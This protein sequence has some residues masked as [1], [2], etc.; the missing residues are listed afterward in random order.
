MKAD[1]KEVVTIRIGGSFSFSGLLDKK[2]CAGLIEQLR[3]Y[4]EDIYGTDR[5]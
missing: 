2:T 1:R 5:R 3:L 4:V